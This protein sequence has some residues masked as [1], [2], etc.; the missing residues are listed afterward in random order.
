M[1]ERLAGTRV[2][3]DQP[4]LMVFGDRAR[5][6]SEGHFLAY[7]AGSDNTRGTRSGADHP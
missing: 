4:G 7:A 5:S 3:A 6:V 2:L 1:M